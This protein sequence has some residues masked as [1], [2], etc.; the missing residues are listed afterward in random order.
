MPQI[1]LYGMC[2][3]LGK[4]ELVNGHLLRDSRLKVEAVPMPACSSFNFMEQPLRGSCLALVSSW[5]NSRGLL[6]TSLCV[7]WNGH[8]ACEGPGP[9]PHSALWGQTGYFARSQFSK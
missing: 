3:D 1:T 6:A 9:S 7:S 5:V 2:E 8:Y 4:A